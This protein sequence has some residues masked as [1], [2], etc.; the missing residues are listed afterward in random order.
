VG[1][2]SEDRLV[3][4]C[5]REFELTILCA[6]STLG[7][8]FTLLSVL[9]FLD[10]DS[11]AFVVAVLNVPGLLGLSAGTAYLLYRCRQAADDP[12]SAIT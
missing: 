9:F 10:S 7:L 5:Q 8:V 12:Q 2:L 4:V 3:Q 1:L 11:G 6:G